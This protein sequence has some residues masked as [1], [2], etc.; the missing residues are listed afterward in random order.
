MS[1]SVIDTWNKMKSLITAKTAAVAGIV[2]P[3]CSTVLS[4]TLMYN[5]AP[6][7][8]VCGTVINLDEVAPQEGT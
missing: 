6:K 7:C 3:T 8:H 1:K 2:C 4:R 5:S